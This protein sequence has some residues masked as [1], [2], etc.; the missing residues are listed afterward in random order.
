MGETG[1]FDGFDWSRGSREEHLA[2]ARDATDMELRALARGY[3]WSKYPETV[4]GWIMAQKCIDL[5]TALSVF[6]NGGPERFN[7]LPKRDVPD[8]LRK[9]AL[10]LDNIC[11]RMNSGF[12]LVWP[13]CDVQDR[14][15]AEA[16]MEAQA[17]D[18][19]EG[20]QG[21]WILDERIVETLLRDKLRIDPACETAIYAKDRSILRDLFSPVMELGVSRR[22]LRFRPPP[23]KTG[24]DLSKLDF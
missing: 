23:N 16:W 11:L 15:R 4:L 10:I 22:V 13:D 20:R 17:L 18:R 24:D 14:R 3:D 1:S 12:Y 7:Y 19:D 9:T 5:G 6:L 21:R 8:H 2:V